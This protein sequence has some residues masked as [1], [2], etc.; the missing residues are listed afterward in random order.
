MAARSDDTAARAESL[1][2]ELDQLINARNR[3]GAI[4]A[5]NAAVTGGALTIPQL[6]ALVLSP[7]MTLTGARWQAGEEEIWEEH[8]TTAVVRTIVESL[9]GEVAAR[10]LSPT[11]RTIVLACAADEYHDLGLRMLADRFAL[12]GYRTHFL[13]AAVPKDELSKAVAE[14][15]ADTVLLSAST[16]YHRVKMREYADALVTASPGLI[17][18]AGGPAFA[19]GHAGWS[20]AEVPDVAAILGDLGEA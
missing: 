1:M 16:H 17:V 20:D 3:E 6:Y 8:Y 11:G 18:W 10:A 7:L 14:L 2:L 5:A 15:G 19:H 12:L 9:H 4:A 13:G